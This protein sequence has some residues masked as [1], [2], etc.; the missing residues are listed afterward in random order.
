MV[1]KYASGHGV[2]TASKDF[3]ANYMAGAGPQAQ[4]AAANN[5]YPAN[6]TA[7]KRVTDPALKQIGI[8]SKGGVPMP[9]IPEMNSVWGDLGD[10]WVK[11]TKGAGSTP[12]KVAFKSAAKNIRAKIA[13][14]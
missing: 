13:G 10:A 1:T 4:L 5:R 3:V 2:A 12:A 7:G 14:G 9:N 8:A 11:S 6:T